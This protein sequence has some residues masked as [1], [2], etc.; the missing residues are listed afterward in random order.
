MQSAIELNDNKN[1]EQWLSLIDGMP[2]QKLLI[3]SIHFVQNDQLAEATPLVNELIDNLMSP[4][5]AGT[6]ESYERAYDNI[7]MLE[8]A[9][10]LQEIIQYK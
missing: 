4:I 5:I 3:Q 9:I 1:V 6:L 10:E 8:Q 7:I 2:G